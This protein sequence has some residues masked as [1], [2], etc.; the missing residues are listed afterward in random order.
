MRLLKTILLVLIIATGSFR[1]WYGATQAHAA[2]IDSISLT[3][4]INAE[5]E[6]RTIPQ[7][8]T[9]QKLIAAAD[10]K[11]KDMFARSYFDH[12]D[13]DG[14]YVWPRIEAAGYRPYKALG[15]NLAIDFS[16]EEGIVAA[17]I[18]SPSHRDNLLREQFKDQGLSSQ[19][20]TFDQ[21]YTN[22]VTSLFGVLASATPPP[23]PPQPQAIPAPPPQVKPAQ[24]PQP[25]PAPTPRPVSDNRN[26]PAALLS[27]PESQ[28]TTPPATTTAFAVTEPTRSASE[29][30]GVY[31]LLRIV[32]I[33]LVLG[34]ISIVAL[35]ALKSRP[36][37]LLK[38]SKLTLIL[39]PL[40][41]SLLTWQWY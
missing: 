34:F 25:A 16:T 23:P 9:S 6:R 15:E 19:Y 4:R 30:Q 29:E 12:I 41:A 26:E 5:R 20:G 27:T 35:D 22:I 3:A 2:N 38:S 32:F 14:H 28:D 37:T 17:W 31:T 1:A 8:T 7:L 10:A 21:R 18:N 39:L 33:V 13:P 11:T 24:S 36:S 40:L